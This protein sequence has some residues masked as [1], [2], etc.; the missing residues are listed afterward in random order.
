MKAEAMLCHPAGF[1]ITAKE[2]TRYY[3]DFKRRPEHG[4]FSSSFVLFVEKLCSQ[5]SKVTVSS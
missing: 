1:L 5:S 2:E 4:L 3:L